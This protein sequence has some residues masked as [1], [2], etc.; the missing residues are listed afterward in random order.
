MIDVSITKGASHDTISVRRAGEE[1]SNFAFP[2]KG[3]I[4]HDYVHF[5]V[6]R[7]LRLRRGFWGM[8]AEG[9][10]PIEIQE[11]AKRGGHASASRPQSPAP[12]IVELI[13]AERLV[14]CFEAD[15]WSGTADNETFRDVASA[16]CAHSF[17][18]CPLL[19]D[20][21]INNVRGQVAAFAKSWTAA[22]VG[23]SFAFRWPG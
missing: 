5:I 20:V 19:D 18:P 7:A 14:E 13:Q 6:E 4:P 2:K 21:M 22:P 9:T 15:L 23:A 10:A 11:M 16:A 8:V 1:V 12:E 3:P 17:V